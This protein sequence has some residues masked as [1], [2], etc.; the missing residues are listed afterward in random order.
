MYVEWHLANVWLE[1]VRVEGWEGRRRHIATLK[2]CGVEGRAQALELSPCL[3]SSSVILVL[4]PQFS[5]Q[6]N[7]DDTLRFVE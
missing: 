4:Q 6:Q 2:Q 7:G 5:Y 1:A 3:N